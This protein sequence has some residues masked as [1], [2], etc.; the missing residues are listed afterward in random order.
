VDKGTKGQRLDRQCA[1]RVR[2]HK[3]DFGEAVSFTVEAQGRKP[4]ATNGNI[5]LRV[6]ASTD[7]ATP[8]TFAGLTPRVVHLDEVAKMAEPHGKYKVDKN[9]KVKN[10]LHW[11]V[12]VS[13]V[14]SE[15]KKFKKNVKVYNCNPQLT[16]SD[17][18]GDDIDDI[19]DGD[20]IV[21]DQ[22][23]DG[24]GD[25]VVDEDAGTCRATGMLGA[26]LGTSNG[27]VSA[28]TGVGV[29][30]IGDDPLVE[31]MVQFSV[32]GTAI[33]PFV[34]QTGNNKANIW[35]SNPGVAPGQHTAVVKVTDSAGQ[36]GVAQFT[37]SVKGG[38]GGTMP[39]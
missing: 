25:D 28:G 8:A 10:N 22:P 6:D 11:H 9:G 31:S 1:V 14:D 36:C 37:Y 30:Y 32:D 29:A 4:T 35:Y 17:D 2:P 16:S 34:Q 18:D 33:T 19:D 27:A 26:V 13:G 21:V 38:S 20:E 3:Y 39:S 12:A 23:G 5:L 24:G 15:G 7:L